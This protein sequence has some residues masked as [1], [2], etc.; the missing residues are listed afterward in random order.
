MF[1]WLTYR[2]PIFWAVLASCLAFAT[3]IGWWL[4]LRPA[5]T[6]WG[7]VSSWVGSVGG[8]IA[9]SIAGRQ[10]RMVLRQRRQAMGDSI[11]V[12]VEKPATSALSQQLQIELCNTGIFTVHGVQIHGVECVGRTWKQISIFQKPRGGVLPSNIS[13]TFWINLTDSQAQ[14]ASTDIGIELLFT[15]IEGHSWRS[16]YTLEGNQHKVSASGRQG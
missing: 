8:L 15:D 13:G 10:L 6:S 1:R 7:T 5:A 14:R 9:L 11:A 2:I 12:I 16:I 3:S 4:E